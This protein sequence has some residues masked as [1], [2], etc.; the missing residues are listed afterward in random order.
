[1]SD[2]T[3]EKAWTEYREHTTRYVEKADF[4]AGWDAR[5]A[6]P[7]APD[8]ETLAKAY[9]PDAFTE[10][11]LNSDLPQVAVIQWASRRHLAYEAADRV[12]ATPGLFQPPADLNISMHKT[13]VLLLEEFAAK[14]GT[15][16]SAYARKVLNTHIRARVGL[17]EPKGELRA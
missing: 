11:A 13:E 5:A 6:A 16:V 1:M 17:S 2:E 10:R 3:R 7:V 8:R 14:D 4:F 15:T 9:D 12:I